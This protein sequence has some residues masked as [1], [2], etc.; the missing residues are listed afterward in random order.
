[1]HYFTAE[2]PPIALVVGDLA[3]LET[4]ASAATKRGAPA[5]E[6]LAQEIARASVV[7]GPEVLSGLVRMGSHVLYRDDVSGEERAVTLVYPDKADI[8]Q[9][10]VSVLTPLGAALI[11][12]SISQSIEFQTPSGGRRSITVL[13]VKEP[14]G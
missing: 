2:L 13:D 7:G 12:L 5:A 6:F 3:R 14:Q 11:G 8:A 4:L 9:G 10:R 1:M